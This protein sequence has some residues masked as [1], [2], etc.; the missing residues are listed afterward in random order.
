[1]VESNNRLLLVIGS[2]PGIGNTVASEF[3]SKRFDK[4][5]L[6]ARSKDRLQQDKQ[7]VEAAAQAAGRNVE[8]RTWS[9]DVVD[10]PN[11]LKALKEIE[12]FGQLDTLFYNAARV[13]PSQFFEHPA[14]EIEYDFKVC[15][16]NSFFRWMMLMYY[17]ITTIALYA[18]AGWAYPLLKKL[19]AEDQ[20]SHPT[21][22]VT[23]SLLPSEPIPQVFALSLTKAAQYNMMKSLSMVAKDDGIHVALISPCGPVSPDFPNLN[24]INIAKKAW[25]LV[26]E[27]RG[28]FTFE[29]QVLE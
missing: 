24:P 6:I 23:S 14:S 27:P 18:V 5:A 22:L 8:V 17:Q 2:G 13:I 19:A 21:I 4:V 7:T 25:E 1:M 20:Q 12:T 3:V 15:T 16:H 28:K 26:A 9:V 29:K 10:T 11:L